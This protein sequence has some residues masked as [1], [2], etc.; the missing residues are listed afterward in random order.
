MRDV[1]GSDRHRSVFENAKHVLNR[2]FIFLLATLGIFTV[3]AY[4]FSFVL[5]KAGSLGV[6][7]SFIPLVY[8]S[9]NV[10]TVLLGLPVGILG[11]R[12]GKVLVL[13]IGY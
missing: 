8:A 11:D 3:G 7:E 10:A 2:K 12:V 5:L 13:G 9:L 1:H 4:N 6:S